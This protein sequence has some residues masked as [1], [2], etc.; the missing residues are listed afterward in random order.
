MIFNQTEILTALKDVKTLDGRIP[1]YQGANIRLEI[2]DPAYLEPTSKYVLQSSLER[3]NSTREKIM[4][5]KGIDIYKMPV[6][7]FHEG[8]LIAPPVVEGNEIVDG[9]H[10]CHDSLHNGR[11]IMVARITGINENL[12][13]IGSSVSWDNVGVVKNKPLLGKDCRELKTNIDDVSINLRTLFRDLSLLGGTGRRP[14]Y[15]QTT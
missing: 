12:P 3:V 5:Q 4:G 9:L 2:V 1:V 13:S 8:F 6:G 7:I 14:S 10:R 11:Q 15:G